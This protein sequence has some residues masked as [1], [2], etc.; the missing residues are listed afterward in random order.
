MT[1]EAESVTINLY[2][3]NS[4]RHFELKLAVISLR[5]PEKNTVCLSMEETFYR[6]FT[7]GYVIKRESLKFVIFILQM[8]W[9]ASVPFELIFIDEL[10]GLKREPVLGS[11]IKSEGLVNPCVLKVEVCTCGCNLTK[12]LLCV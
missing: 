2:S 11:K 3:T 5:G 12:L 4:S 7:L 9:S 1:T 8:Q 10:T 6:Y